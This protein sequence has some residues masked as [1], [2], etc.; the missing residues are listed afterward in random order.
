[1]ADLDLD[2]K[3][4]IRSIG[5]W[6]KKGIIFRDI[7]PLLADHGAFTAAVDALCEQFAQVGVEYVAAIEARGFIFASVIA[8]RLKVGFVPIRKE[9]KLPYEVQRYEYDLEYGK[10]VLEVH[11]DA[12]PK[13]AKVL[14]VDDLL[15]TGGSMEASCRLIEQIGGRVVG[16]SCLIELTDLKGRDKL[17]GYNF[18][19]V[20]QY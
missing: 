11:T 12:V 17:A 5:D 2:L 7:T 20:L 6:P 8:D 19:S 3:K 18:K 16:I 15:A 1:M 10:D 13:G 14:V 9:G 4:Y